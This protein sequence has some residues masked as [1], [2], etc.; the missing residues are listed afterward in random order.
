[1]NTFKLLS[2]VSF[3]FIVCQQCYSQTLNFRNLKTNDRHLATLNAGLEYG[4]ICGV[5]Y[6]YQLK[7]KIPVLLNLDF[8]AP[9]GDNEVDDFKTK[10]GAQIR[11]Y[12]SGNFYLSGKL[13]GIYRQNINDFVRLQNFGAEL[14]A[15]FGYYKPR[16]FTA[17]E[18]G[19]DKAIITRFKHSDTYK[20]IYP[21]VQDGWS[22]P[23]TGGNFN[24]GLLGGYS[25]KQSDLFIKGG[26]VTTEDLSKPQLPVYAQLGYT[27]RFRSR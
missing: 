12:H 25:F 15:T 4:L 27:I 2:F 6:S 18:A 24:V 3:S 7:S 17:V 16:W 19:F 8:S 23:P 11:I 9:S 20:Q 5:G 13:H 22:E 10:A 26:I 21:G 14:S 1:M